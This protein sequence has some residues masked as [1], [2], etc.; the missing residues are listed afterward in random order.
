MKSA[1][2]AANGATVDVRI[3]AENGSSSRD[4]I[5]RYLCVPN[6]EEK[7]DV[8][9]KPYL[10]NLVNRAASQAIPSKIILE[11]EKA[12]K[13]IGKAAAGPEEVPLGGRR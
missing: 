9:L 5:L 3:K 11:Q 6:T 2:K 10:Q 7:V 13:K 4:G 8:D 12:V 1:F